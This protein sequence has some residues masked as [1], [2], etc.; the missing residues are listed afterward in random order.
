MPNHVP[1]SRC[2]TLRLLSTGLM[3]LFLLMLPAL[4]HADPV[5]RYAAP[6]PAGSGD[7]R[8]WADACTLPTALASAGSGDE[9]WVQMGVH[10][11]T[12]TADRTISFALPAGVA[13]YGGFAGTETQLAE[14]DWQT[15]LTILSGDIDNNDLTDATGVVTDTAN[16]VGANSYHVVMNP[17]NNTGWLD[18]FTITSGQANGSLVLDQDKGGGLYSDIA[19]NLTVVNT[20]FSGNMAYNGGGMYCEGHSQYLSYLAFTNVIFAGNTAVQYGGGLNNSG[21]PLTLTHVQFLNN[22]AG[23]SGGGMLTGSPNAVMTDLTFSGNTAT[24]YGGG[25][26]HYLGSLT[27]TDATF[28]NNTAFTGGGLYNM[29][30][31][32]NSDSPTLTAV[33]FQDNDAV[34]GGGLYTEFGGFTLID[35]DIIGNTAVYG[36]GI[37]SYTGSPT[38][39]VVTFSG[40]W[41]DFGGGM[42]NNASNPSLTNVI[43]EGNTAYLSGGAMFNDVNSDPTLVNVTMQNNTAV[44]ANGGGIY[45]SDISEPTIFDSIIWGNNAAQNGDQIYNDN[46]LPVIAYSDVQSSGGSGS[47]WDTALGVDGGGNLDADPRFVA[48][49]AGDLHLGPDSPAI[50]A[51]DNTAVP[52]GIVTDLDGR[53][54]FIDVPFLPDSGSGTRPL[55]DMGAYEASFADLSLD[56]TVAPAVAA[57]GEMLTFTLTLNNSSSLTVTQVVLTDTLPAHLTPQAVLASG[58]TITDTGVSPA[59][60]WHVA[61]LAPDQSGVI[62]LSAVLTVPLP[63]GTY[64]NTAY[65]S[66]A[67]DTWPLN[68][69]ASIT[70]TVANVAPM[71]TS[72]AVPTATQD[73]P[74]TYAITAS[75]GNGDS[76]TIT[77]PVLPDWLSLTDNGDGTAVLSG[78]P[79]SAD[80]G[81]HAVRLR[82]TDEADRYSEQT[83]SVTVLAKPVF[84]LYLPLLVQGER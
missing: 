20:I 49:T 83:F 75:D 24:D 62:T 59:F 84:T 31:P 43:F 3:A 69:S 13:V 9:V 74:Y 36:G 56:K 58:I 1:D 60:V 61:D 26:S 70:Y 16:I 30:D 6:A 71:F 38:L 68:N 41:G 46:T 25:M 21:N 32:A 76:L 63:A 37:H 77:A 7:C 79:T 54:R 14:R 50:D 5:V 57:P 82:V 12:D 40:N 45:N 81:D 27:L 72:T 19:S 17:A 48:P 23:W 52:V 29:S 66:A 51:G 44:S 55:V 39:T 67:N 34:L 47:G 42:Y 73:A 33:T 80:V 2:L 28:S 11:P 53:S 4:S 65:L 64:T 78:T 22:S 18:G 10:K 35:V 8:S 15:N